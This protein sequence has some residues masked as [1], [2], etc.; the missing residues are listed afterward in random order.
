[1]SLMS[2]WPFFFKNWNTLALQGCSFLLYKEV[3]QL[4]VCIYPLPLGPPSH[5]HL[6][7]HTPLGQRGAQS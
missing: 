5:P 2:P 6:P 1:M 3:N 7:Y 4:L